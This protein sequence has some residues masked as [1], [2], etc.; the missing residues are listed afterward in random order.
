MDINPFN[1][2]ICRKNNGEW[3][4]RL[5]DFDSL[6]NTEE[7]T[8]PIYYGAPRFLPSDCGYDIRNNYSPADKAPPLS[9]MRAFAKLK[10]FA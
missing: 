10:Y 4:A 7:T 9:V 1:I 6:I 3:Y 8:I 2:L 5:C